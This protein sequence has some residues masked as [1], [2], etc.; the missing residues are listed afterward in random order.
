MDHVAVSSKMELK[1][2]LVWDL[3]SF[4]HF[5]AQVTSFGLMGKKVK[6][7]NKQNSHKTNPLEFQCHYS[8]I[9]INIPQHR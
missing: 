9:E 1:K 2:L 8:E 7:K 5:L 3:H 6:S 4:D